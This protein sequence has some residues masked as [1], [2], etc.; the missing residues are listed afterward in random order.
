MSSPYQG[1]TLR[2]L[3]NGVPVMRIHYSADPEMTP[4]VVESL[5]RK[6]LISQSE[7][8]WNR[9]YEVEYEALEGE[10]LFPN[11][12]PQ[13]NN[14][15]PFDCTDPQHWTWYMGCD[16]HGRTP[17]GFIWTAF[18][19][20][21]D[22]VIAN[23]LFQ[24]PLRSVK[25]YS[26]T[27]IW[28]ESDSDDKPWQWWPGQKLTIYKRIMDTHGS[29]VNSDEGE[30]Y[31]KSY[32]KHKLNF[33][34][35][36]KGHDILETARDEINRL[37]L[38]EKVV[39]SEGTR[40]LPRLYVSTVCVQTI[41]QLENVRFPS[42]EVERISDERPQTFVRHLVDPL[43]YIFSDKPRFVSRRKWVDQEEAIYSGTA[44]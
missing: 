31:F 40:Y 38:P 43:T 7:A 8:F 2:R 10:R 13:Y 23:E 42:G 37:L 20:S 6:I 26:E 3:E 30:D 5:K 29:A 41:E 32:R 28:L 14:T 1:V 25:E 9:E 21:G 16:P 19:S 27:I 18:G 4:E 44:Y 35:A 15:Q 12:A 11:Y 24:Y 39:T 17:H 22:S 33:I 34:P 36:K